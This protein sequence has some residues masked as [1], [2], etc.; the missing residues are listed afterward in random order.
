MGSLVA[1]PAA[2]V[3]AREAGEAQLWLIVLQGLVSHHALACGP[4]ARPSGT[5]EAPGRSCRRKH[6]GV[7]QGRCRQ[8]APAPAE[9]TSPAQGPAVR[10][11]PLPA[12]RQSPAPHPRPDPLQPHLLCPCCC[13]LCR[14]CFSLRAPRGSLLPSSPQVF[15]QMFSSQP[16]FPRPPPV[17]L[18]PLPILP[19]PFSALFSQSCPPM[20]FI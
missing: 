11:T 3:D 9:G 15:A 13:F 18:Q 4:G 12:P 10:P 19:Q 8:P 20:Y 7:R 1:L 2:A 6:R 5:H 17:K 14:D 16:D